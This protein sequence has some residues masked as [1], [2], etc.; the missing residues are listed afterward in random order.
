MRLFRP[1]PLL[2]LTLALCAPGCS[3]TGSQPA[4]DAPQQPAPPARGANAPLEHTQAPIVRSDISATPPVQPKKPAPAA[5]PEKAAVASRPEKAMA[6]AKPAPKATPAPT[7]REEAKAGKPP[8]NLDLGK[9][10]LSQGKNYQISYQCQ[11]A[12]A[13]RPQE[14]KVKVV[15]KTGKPV[16]GAKVRLSGSSPQNGHKLNPASLEAKNQGHGH[17]LAKGLT[18]AQPGWWVVTV[19]VINSGRNDRA[20]FNL[21]LK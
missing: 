20:Q 21:L 16:T 4:E 14:W 13:K 18:F 8:K 19:E 7:P 10:K 11:P 17:Y 6:P 9:S 15:T 3:S 2:L 5:R 1:V 12:Q